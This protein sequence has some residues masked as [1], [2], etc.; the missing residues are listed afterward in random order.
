MIP[1]Q[2]LL[3]RAER[4]GYRASALS[5]LVVQAGGDPAAVV[6]AWRLRDDSAWED[7]LSLRHRDLGVGAAWLDGVPLYVL[8]FGVSKA[9][10]FA[11]R[12]R[13][14][15]DP[16]RVRAELLASVNRERKKKKL[17][18]LRSNPAL[19]T[20]AQRHV[21]DMLARGYYG[22]SSPEGTMVM[23]RVRRAG[24]EAERVGENIAKGQGSVEEAMDGWMRSR[25]HRENILNPFFADAGFGVALGKMPEGDQV[26]WVQV[27]GRPHGR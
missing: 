21:D 14:L 1:G 16:A 18:P 5:Q 17:P 24:Y 11:S 6:D 8:F 7:I 9:D 19:E 26:I 2:D 10:A 4:E 27:F 3:D 25:E 13:G 20:A 15:R 22:H 23:R 12:T